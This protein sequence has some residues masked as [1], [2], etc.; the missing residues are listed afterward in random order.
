MRYP[1]FYLAWRY[2]KS[3]PTET[4]IALMGKLCFI[5][6][7]ISTFSL[8]LV[9]FVM[10]GF[11]KATHNKLQGIHAQ[12]IIRGYGDP[13]DYAP[14]AQVLMREFSDIAAFSPTSMRQ[15]L[16]ASHT[17]DS[18]DVVIIKGIDPER[19]A[20]VSSIAH[21]MRGNKQ[22][23]ITL[24]Q[25]VDDTHIALGSQLAKALDVIPGDRVTLIYTESTQTRSRKIVF[26]E[27]EI[28]VGGIFTTGIDEFDSSMILCSLSLFNHLFP[29][30]GIDEIH[31]TL[32][33]TAHEEVTM[34]R[35][36]ER[37][38]LDVYSWKHL[39][40]ALVSALK[41]ETYAMLIIFAL[42]ALVA[43]MSIISLLFMHITYKRGDIAILKAMGMHDSSIVSIFLTMGMTIASVGC[44]FGIALALVAGLL[45]QR[46]PLITLPDAYY[47]S[48]LPIAIEWHLI[49]LV[50]IVVMLL[51]FIAT[52]IPARK[53]RS[54][55][56][57]QVLRFE[58]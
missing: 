25:A 32:K 43:S 41:L 2:L 24:A 51:S 55:V 13:L 1:S 20:T 16:L 39:Y 50:M 49:V 38:Q 31:L 52:W 8:T 28:I 36:R 53:T 46:Y 37:L 3:S 45:L 19:E 26:D 7:V 27:K 44:L 6:I 57:A 56:I 30:A 9:L 11:E 15:G 12:V 40:P 33:P 18:P 47:I 34:Q 42:I 21:K 5:G 14:I 58:A 17:S 48:H 35:L 4:T 23:P 22:I 54:L 10:R 29:D